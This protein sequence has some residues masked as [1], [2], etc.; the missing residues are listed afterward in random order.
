MARAS[1][2]EEIAQAA[3]DQF[4]SHGFHATGI[5]DITAAA[6]APKG[7]FYNH[8]SSKE[9]SALEALSRYADSLRFDILFTPGQPALDRLRA[10]FEFLRRMTVDSG[11]ARGCL[12]GNF[13]VEVADHNETIRSA[14]RQSFD[15]WAGLISRVLTEAREAGELGAGLDA[16]EAARF[17][18]SA[19]EGTLIVARADKTSIPFDSFFHMVFG[20]VLR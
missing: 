10:H 13:G 9:E 18:L 17:I 20:V 19:W 5:N 16:D 7:S 11:F 15:Q 12:V 6:G 14:V 2:R 1:K 3:L 8:F 4:H